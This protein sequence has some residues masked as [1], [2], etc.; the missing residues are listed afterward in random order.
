MR[1]TIDLATRV[2]SDKMQVHLVRPGAGYAFYPLIM[3]QQVIPVDAPFLQLTDGKAVPPAGKIASELERARVLRIWAN[4]S[5]SSRGP[6]P[7]TGIEGY[8]LDLADPRRASTR[9]KIR[10]AAQKVL[11]TIPGGTLVVIPPRSLAGNAVLAEI[12]SRKDPR[13][14]VKGFGPNSGLSYPARS[15]RNLKLVPM[16]ELPEQVIKSSRTVRVVEKLSGHGEDRILR[17]YYGD[18]QRAGSRV[19]GLIAGTEDFDARVIGQMIELHMAVEHA[20]TNRSALKP[21]QA[22]FDPSVQASPFFH[23]R[24][25]SPDGRTHLESSSIATLVVKLFLVVAAAGLSPAEAARAIESDCVTILNNASG[26]EQQIIDAS[27]EALVD[28]A[29]ITGHQCVATYLEALQDGL[30][31]NDASISGDATIEDDL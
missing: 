12:S 21:G 30:N 27:R 26:D 4:S 17:L 9:T 15:L 2:L 28:F 16:R 18:Y 1:L 22:L 29:N 23:G 13:V 31:R 24:V 7:S 8:R 19:A 10:N 20:I 6:R 25:D 11:W 14:T 5:K 3:S